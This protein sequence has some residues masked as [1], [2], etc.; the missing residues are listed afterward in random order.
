MGTI[1][2]FLAIVSSVL[3]IDKGEPSCECMC[4]KLAVSSR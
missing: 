3:F 1:L 4:M 2:R